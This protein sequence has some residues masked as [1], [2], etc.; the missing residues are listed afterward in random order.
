M[1]SRSTNFR[2]GDRILGFD[3]VPISGEFVLHPE[4]IEGSFFMDGYRKNNAVLPYFNVWHN[5]FFLLSRLFANSSRLTQLQ[6]DAIASFY[7]LWLWSHCLAQFIYEPGAFQAPV[8]QLILVGA[9]SKFSIAL[10]SNIRRTNPAILV[11][12]LTSAMHVRLVKEL[13]LCHSVFSYDQVHLI[14]QGRRSAVADVTGAAHIV[15][16]VMS[17]LRG[18][19]LQWKI[20]PLGATH[21]LDSNG[22]LVAYQKRSMWSDALRLGSTHDLTT[23]LVD[24]GGSIPAFLFAKMTQ[25]PEFNPA[26]LEDP[27]WDYVSLLSIVGIKLN[28]LVGATDFVQNFKLMFWGASNQ[29]AY[30]FRRDRF[31]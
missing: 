18:N 11:V 26:I 14:N 23:K 25:D 2:A 13:H 17:H 22:S 9:S 27:F 28:V 15:S 20:P 29:S 30:I 8:E 12:C 7:P 16:G 6:L 5:G 1:H 19:L 31:P 24:L 10:A 3:N 21:L 4:H